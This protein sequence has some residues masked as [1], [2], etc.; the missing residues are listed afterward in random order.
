MLSLEPELAAPEIV[1]ELIR[2]PST[3][4]R[5]IRAEIDETGTERRYLFDVERN[6]GHRSM[7]SVVHRRWRVQTGG[8]R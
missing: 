1:W 2:E 3:P 4:Q 5:L 6:A 7:E 8:L